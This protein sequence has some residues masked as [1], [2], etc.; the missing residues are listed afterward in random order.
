MQ[1]ILQ[2]CAATGAPVQKLE[3]GAVLLVEGD[4]SGRLYVLKEGTVEV[5]RGDTMVALVHQPG[6]VFGE[7]SGL[8]GRPHSATVRATT[9]NTPETARSSATDANAPVATV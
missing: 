8:L 5:M 2:Y 9:P 4:S 6:A 1:S 7:M 3:A